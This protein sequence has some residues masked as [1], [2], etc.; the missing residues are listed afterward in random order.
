MLEYTQIEEDENNNV[1]VIMD[2]YDEK[3]TQAFIEKSRKVHGDTYD[4]KFVNYITNRIHV[5]IGCK[6]HG[7]FPQPPSGHTNRKN[8]CPICASRKK[9][10]QDYQNLAKLKGYTYILDTVPDLTKTSIKGWKCDNGHTWEANYGNIYSGTSCPDCLNRKKYGLQDYKD[11][12]LL[13]NK[14]YILDTIPE[15]VH[16]P[17]KGWKCIN[18]HIWEA[19][20]GNIR[21]GRGCPK[22]VA[23][24]YSQAQLEWLTY[25]EKR[26]NIKIQTILSEKGEHKIEGSFY[27]VDGYH[28]ESET[29][30]EFHGCFWHGHPECHDPQDINRSTHEPFQELYDKTKKKEEHILAYD[31][32]LVVIW[33]C[34]WNELKKTL[35]EDEYKCSKVLGEEVI[36]EETYNDEYTEDEIDE[37]D[38]ITIH[39]NDLSR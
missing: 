20:Y 23:H 13:K 3:K 10:L 5:I 27:K 31:Y 15:N 21:G 18:G 38:C 37:D 39:E 12:A 9:F 34:E 29:C 4:Y 7:Y 33:E 11:L 24:T 8:K 36:D 1:F 26:D 28:K 25:I 16:T 30:Y 17:I 2:K 32:N 35:R 19:N 14:E 22:C 6:I